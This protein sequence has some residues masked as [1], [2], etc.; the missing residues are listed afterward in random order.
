MKWSFSFES[1]KG[2]VNQT[3]VRAVDGS[4]YSQSDIS[5]FL[6]PQTRRIAQANCLFRVATRTFAVCQFYRNAKRFHWFLKCMCMYWLQKIVIEHNTLNEFLILSAWSIIFS[7]AHTGLNHCHFGKIKPIV[8]IQRQPCILRIDRSLLILGSR[9]LLGSN[10]STLCDSC[11][12]YQLSRSTYL[13][14]SNERFEWIVK[15][16]LDF[17][18]KNLIGLLISFYIWNLGYNHFC[19]AWGFVACVWGI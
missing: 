4:L 11:W 10:L 14:L 12:L 13:I 3:S 9:F 19:M 16:G 7:V 15:F 17:I 5:E 1:R 6:L 2:K 18:S 8:K